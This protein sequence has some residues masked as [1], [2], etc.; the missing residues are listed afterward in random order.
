M[1]RILVFALLFSVFPL[2]PGPQASPSTAHPPPLSVSLAPALLL[3]SP[4]D[5]NAGLFSL[6]GGA[7]IAIEY[8]LPFFPMLFA[9]AGF[10]YGYNRLAVPDSLSIFGGFGGLGVR[11]PL[12]DW[13]ALKVTAEGGY[14][15]SFVNSTA[16]AEA[17]GNGF[18]S[19]GGGLIFSP[20]PSFGIGIGADYR[21]YFNYVQMIGASVAVSYAFDLPAPT[22]NEFGPR[23]ILTP[24][25]KVQ[26]VSF[27]S[28]FPIFH[29]Y[30]DDPPWAGC[31]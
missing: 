14:Y 26:D 29:A 25:L 16:P 2:S 10:G 18:V 6:G 7:E 3:P 19:L 9:R 27:E 31:H 28:V 20:W 11:V 4:L 1:K 22:K 24:L 5:P 12:L 23:P 21:L 30:Y 8:A 13:L 15:Y 17:A